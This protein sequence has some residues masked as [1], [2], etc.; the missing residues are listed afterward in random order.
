MDAIANSFVKKTI[1]YE[2]IPSASVAGETHL[3]FCSN[4]RLFELDRDEKEGELLLHTTTD[5]K[6]MSIDRLPYVYLNGVSCQP[7]H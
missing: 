7:G 2:E 6:Q 1:K 4:L 3:K 5:S